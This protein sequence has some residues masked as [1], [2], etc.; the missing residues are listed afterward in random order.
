M[1]NIKV[2][3]WERK[4]LHEQSQYVL[5][6]CQYELELEKSGLPVQ[7]IESLVAEKF[8]R[9]IESVGKKIKK[10]KPNVI[11]Q[12]SIQKRA[13]RKAKMEQEREFIL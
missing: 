5:K 13:N 10:Q 3:L 7:E 12:F 11:A 1:A 9:P 2:V 8:P 6:K 4:I